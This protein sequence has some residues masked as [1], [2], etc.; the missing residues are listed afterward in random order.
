[1]FESNVVAKKKK[2]NNVKLFYRIDFKRE[3]GGIVR[4]K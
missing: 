4:D 1:M 3:K 2:R